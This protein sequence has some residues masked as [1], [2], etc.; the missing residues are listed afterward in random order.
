M[1]SELGI[2]PDSKPQ[3]NVGPV[4]IWWSTWACFWTLTVVLGMA[5]LIVNRNAPPVRVRGLTLS[6][7]AMVLLHLYWLS[8]QFGTLIGNIMPGDAEF[9]VMGLYL[10]I[11]MGLF[12][13]SN[14]QFLHVAN[15]QKKYARRESIVDSPNKESDKTS[16]LDRFRRL[17]YR[18]KMF[19]IVGIAMVFQVR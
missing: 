8:V 2:N 13:A 9:W 17:E 12:H 11:G 1:G 14:T 4:S 16:L 6:L 10:P 5:F 7:A 15:V 18:T 3:I 19:I